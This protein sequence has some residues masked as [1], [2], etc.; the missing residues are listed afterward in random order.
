MNA[1]LLREAYL[2]C[3]AR[4]ARRDKPSTTRRNFAPI[5]IFLMQQK[6]GQKQ[7]ADALNLDPT[8]ISALCAGRLVID[9]QLNAIAKYLN[10]SRKKLNGMIPDRRAA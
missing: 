6:I 1:E 3:I 9:H 4:K 8:T 2:N 10:I 5:H 7:I